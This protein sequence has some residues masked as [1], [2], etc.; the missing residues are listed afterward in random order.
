MYRKNVE[1]KK[2][3][4]CNNRHYFVF[5]FLKIL[6]KSVF[7]N[8]IEKNKTEMKIQEV[9]VIFLR[10]YYFA[11]K[12]RYYDVYDSN[13][14]AYTPFGMFQHNLPSTHPIHAFRYGFSTLFIYEP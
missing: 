6:W 8:F 9:L 1:I 12:T 2:I 14:E 11:H 10:L 7:N 5:L 4:N 3:T 13:L